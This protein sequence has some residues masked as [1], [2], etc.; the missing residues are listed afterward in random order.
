MNVTVSR[1]GTLIAVS[2]SDGT[3]ATSAE[4]PYAEDG[5]ILA[6]DDDKKLY[7]WVKH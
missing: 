7:R 4:V 6:W 1:F 3:M 5:K 2:N